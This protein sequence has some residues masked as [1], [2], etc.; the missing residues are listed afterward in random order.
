MKHY[1]V[2]VEGYE[3]DAEYNCEHFEVSRAAEDAL[4]AVRET[5]IECENMV[6]NGEEV[7]RVQRVIETEMCPYCRSANTKYRGE[8]IDGWFVGMKCISW[9]CRDCNGEFPT[10]CED[11]PEWVIE[12]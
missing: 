6:P 7:F 12:L 4:A 11:C 9:E 1:V 5:L 8:N 3:P 10:N 2:F